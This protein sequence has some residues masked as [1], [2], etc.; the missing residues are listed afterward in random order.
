VF[1]LDTCLIVGRG[2]KG[3][4]YM[5]CWWDIVVVECTVLGFHLV[6]VGIQKDELPAGEKRN[7][8]KV[9]VWEREQW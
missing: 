9:V 3:G 7:G 2:K 6:V 5:V 8:K 4:C 1:G